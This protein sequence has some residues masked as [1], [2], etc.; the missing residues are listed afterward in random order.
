MTKEDIKL[1]LT[2]YCNQCIKHSG[3]TTCMCHENTHPFSLKS[4]YKQWNCLKKI[5][6]INMLNNN[7]QLLNNK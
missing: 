2:T 3:Y 6:F 5:E 1:V 4:E 7:Y